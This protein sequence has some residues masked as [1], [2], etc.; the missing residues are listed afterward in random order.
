MK[1][2][3]VCVCVC[4]LGSRVDYSTEELNNTGTGSREPERSSLGPGAPGPVEI[5]ASDA[6]NID[7]ARP[8]FTSEAS[9][10]NYE[11]IHFFDPSQLHFFFF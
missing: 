1:G 4:D 10:R 11:A 2:V 7:F 5:T 3:C 8:V 9:R 6:V